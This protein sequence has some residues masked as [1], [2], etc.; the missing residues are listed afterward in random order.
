MLPC[1]WGGVNTTFAKS[2]ASELGEGEFLL[3][4][5]GAGKYLSPGNAW[6]THAS[7][8]TQDMLVE[9][10]KSGDKYVLSTKPYFGD[11]ERWITSG[12]Y[13]DSN[14]YLI[15]RDKLD[16]EWT[17]TTV[18]ATNKIYTIATADDKKLTWDGTSTLVDVIAGEA[19]ANNEWQLIKVDLSDATTESPVDVSH[20][21]RNAGF[22]AFGY[23]TSKW[24]TS[25]NLVAVNK[26]TGNQATECYNNN[27]SLQQ[28]ITGL[29]P[30]KYRVSCQ[31]FYRAGGYADAA[32]K[33]QNSTEEQNVTLFANDVTK[34]LVSIFSEAGKI[35]EV[36]VNTNAGWIPN[37]TTQGAQYFDKGLYNNSIEVTVQTDGTLT[38]GLKKENKVGADWTMIDNFKLEYLGADN[39][40]VLNDTKTECNTL[41]SSSE[42]THV[43]GK[44]RTD[45]KQ[46]VSELT[47]ANILTKSPEVINLCTA[48][49]NAK[50]TYNDFANQVAAAKA[51]EVSTTDYDSY[52]TSAITAADIKT[53]LQEL[54]VAVYNK[55]TTT[56]TVDM[57]SAVSTTLPNWDGDAFGTANV[58]QSWAGANS[59]E[60]AGKYYESGK[61][62][63]TTAWTVSKNKTIS[64]VPGSYVMKLACRTSN[65]GGASNGTASVTVG[66]ATLS[67]TFPVNSDN[68]K[69][70]STDGAANFAE[71]GTYCNTTGRGWEW[72]F[73]PFTVTGD[74]PQEVK[75]SVELSSEAGKNYPGLTSPVILAAPIPSSLS[76]ETTYAVANPTAANVT[77]TRPL[78]TGGWNT[79]VLPFAVSAEQVKSQFGGEAKVAK[80]TGST[81]NVLNFETVES[82]LEANVPYLVK[83]SQAQPEGGYQFNNVVLVKGENTPVGAE[84]GYQFVGNYS[85]E[86]KLAAGNFF[87]NAEANKFYVSKNGGEAVKAYRAYFTAPAEPKTTVLSISFNGNGETTGINEVNSAKTASSFD[88]YSIDGILVKKNATSLTGLA[89]GIYIVNGKKYI[90]Q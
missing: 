30:G 89:K 90:A 67:A 85:A 55:V 75:L 45:L 12:G 9:I 49:K 19:T 53:K 8:S 88:V 20:L 1:Y 39:S 5:V 46:I 73:I 51:L 41:L 15:D 21:V 82:V 14:Q 57:T 63:T 78:K 68:G 16:K 59:Q 72:R 47:E 66:N 36:G 31:G 7:I 22:E 87:I 17:F 77:L 13:V 64:L 80:Y 81:N 26:N 23:D 33:H 42:Y 38:L 40:K 27:F 50:I 65:N 34:P 70:I 35:G 71:G 74:A 48:F 2:V 76:E 37:N 56:Y 6:G 44:E 25:G 83:P 24:T 62:E 60:E 54:N 4:N 61:Y 32:T 3:K 29:T 58:W 84:D 52:I 69:G 43:T 11:Q 79:L 18:D 10:T 86:A 28:T